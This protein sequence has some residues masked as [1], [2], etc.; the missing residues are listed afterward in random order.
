MR[1]LIKARGVLNLL[2][3]QRHLVFHLRLNLIQFEG[4]RF[5]R[6]IIRHDPIVAILTLFL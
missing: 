1:L 4:C 3:L 6:L 5:A 2:L